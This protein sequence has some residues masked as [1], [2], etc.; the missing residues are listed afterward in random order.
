MKCAGKKQ[1]QMK[2][3]MV[4]QLAML[5][6]ATPGSTLFIFTRWSGT[7]HGTFVF[8]QN[9]AITYLFR[10]PATSS[11]KWESWKVR[12]KEF[13]GQIRRGNNKWFERYVPF[14]VS[15]CNWLPFQV[16][17]FTGIWN[18]AGKRHR[19]GTPWRFLLN[20]P[21]SSSDT[22][23][24]CPRRVLFRNVCNILVIHYGN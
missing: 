1:D 13:L 18:A 10:A 4:W 17:R 21:I 6:R 11:L 3:L 22:S 7:P 14:Q 20:S 9:A 16:F 2:Q 15:P 24:N 19:V 23:L 5:G 12:P 8:L